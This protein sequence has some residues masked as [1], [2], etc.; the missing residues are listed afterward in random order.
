MKGVNMITYQTGR[1]YDGEQVLQISVE[2]ESV[3][4]YGLTEVVATFVD[5]SRHIKGR[6]N[7][8]IFNDGIG[9][10]VLSAYDAGRYE[11]LTY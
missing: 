1:T 5:Q 9:A 8:I 6:V 7:T 11:S 10:A 3:D 4:E 2:S